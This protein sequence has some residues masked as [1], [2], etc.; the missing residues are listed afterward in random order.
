MTAT[1]KHEMKKFHVLPYP[2]QASHSVP[3]R[4]GHRTLCA[5]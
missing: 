2:T 1:S 5:Q 4:P 3:D